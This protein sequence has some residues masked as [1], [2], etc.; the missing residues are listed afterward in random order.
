[1][2]YISIGFIIGLVAGVFGSGWTFVTYFDEITPEIRKIVPEMR[3]LKARAKSNGNFM[4]QLQ[5]SMDAMFQAQRD[6]PTRQEIHDIVM[7]AI[8]GC[9]VVGFS[10]ADIYRI[11]CPVQ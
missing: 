1:M 10:N 6:R 5:S 4:E 8:H 11:E 7:H 2:K 3:E 9:N